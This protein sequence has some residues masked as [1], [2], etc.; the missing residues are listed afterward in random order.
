MT[1]AAEITAMRGALMKAQ[2]CFSLSLQEEQVHFFFHLE[3]WTIDAN[4]AQLLMTTKKFF[5]KKSV[6][7]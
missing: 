4:F 3:F 1:H 5:E 6:F 7:H 2:A